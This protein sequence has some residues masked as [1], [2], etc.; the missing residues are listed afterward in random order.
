MNIAHLLIQAL[1]RIITIKIFKVTFTNAINQVDVK[2]RAFKAPRLE[3]STGKTMADSLSHAGR[4][5]GTTLMLTPLWICRTRGT[6]P[7]C[8]VVLTQTLLLLCKSSA[9][10]HQ[11][12][13]SCRRKEQQNLIFVIKV[14]C[15]SLVCPQ[16]AEL[17]SKKMPFSCSHCSAQ[18]SLF[19]LRVQFRKN[20]YWG[21]PNLLI[22]EVSGKFC[23][24]ENWQIKP[25]RQFFL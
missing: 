24:S 20:P 1:E 12:W 9:Q 7:L 18:N 15:S 3:Y 23:F 17:M 4:G 8:K 11:L 16:E 21:Q 19:M 14:R 6:W 10:F 25:I 5:L 13:R 2:Q 22:I